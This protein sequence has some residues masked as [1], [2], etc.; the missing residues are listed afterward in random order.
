VGQL[1]PVLPLACVMVA[2]PQI[3]SAIFLAT[4]DHWARHSAAYL[5]GAATSVTLIV[6]ITYVITR[7][8]GS[9]LGVSRHRPVRNGI[10]IGLAALLLVLALLVFRRRG[11]TGPPRWMGKLETAT[12]RLSFSLGF[13]LLGV[14]PSDLI[15]SVAVGT[16][17]AV[18]GYPWW[19]M[20][21]FIFVVLL[22]LA[23]PLLLAVLLGRHADEVL[24]KIR[25]WMNRNAWIVSEV[26]IIFFLAL[27]VAGLT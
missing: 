23:V 12:G 10:D 13:L 21:I 19:H 4:S 16:R 26:V 22:L 3:V 17:T 6:T 20:A 11:Q 8:A 18:H 9:V 14:F 24:P 27:I 1:L 2:G 7:L 25:N 5:A 15:T